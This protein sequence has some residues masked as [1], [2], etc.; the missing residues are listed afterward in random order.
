ME[1]V[2][3]I[4]P[5]CSAWE[6]DVLPLNYTRASS[7]LYLT[8]FFFTSMFICAEVH[9][10]ISGE[11]YLITLKNNASVR[12]PDVFLKRYKSA[13][14]AALKVALY[15]F[16]CGSAEVTDI[17]SALGISSAS[18]ERSLEFWRSAGLF[19]DNISVSSV[20]ANNT[21]EPVNRHLN[22]SDIASLILSD[23]SISML[24]Q[25][26]Q[27]LIGRELSFSESRLLVETIQ[28][29]GLDAEAILMIESYFQNTEHSRKVLTDTSRAAREMAK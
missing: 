26:T 11:I 21:I 10:I 3:G 22:H 29:C 12:L 2:K 1:R 16:E 5:S 13:D 14:S 20:G 28:D 27:K 8:L 23:S 25:E 19:E 6:A 24:L 4:E 18:V 7:I 17:E 15:L 9:M